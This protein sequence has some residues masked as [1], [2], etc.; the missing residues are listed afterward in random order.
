[1]NY[2]KRLGNW[3]V[4]FF[5]SDLAKRIY[6]LGTEILKAVLKEQ[7]PLLQQIALDEV[8]KAAATSLSNEDK[9]EMAY[10]AIVSRV[11]NSDIGENAINLAIELAVAAIKKN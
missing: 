7:G 5:K 6:Q 11:K 9:F 10:K 2:F 4:S 3:V 1:M 8:R